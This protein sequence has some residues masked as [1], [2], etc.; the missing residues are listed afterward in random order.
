APEQAV[1]A[2]PIDGRADIYSLGCTLFK[3][4]TGR[5]PFGGPEYESTARKLYAHCHIGLD[6]A[7]GFA[8]IPAPLQSVLLRMTAKEPAERYPSAREAAHA[9]APL[10]EQGRPAEL[11]LA[12]QDAALAVQPLPRPLPEEVS[13]LTV[14]P[15]ETREPS[16]EALVP[17]VPARPRR[18]GRRPV[19]AAFLAGVLATLAVV[20]ALNWDRKP[21]KKGPG[22]HGPAVALRQLDELP[23]PRY[24]VLLDRPPLSNVGEPDPRQW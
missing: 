12:G 1:A 22:N 4:L 6:K 5:A 7:E 23:A 8:S 20:V 14:A 24:F 17:R 21:E 16:P 15:Q 18:L 19:A 13:R 2:G 9:L 11:A 3:L 10:A